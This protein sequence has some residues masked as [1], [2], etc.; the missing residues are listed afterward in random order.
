MEWRGGRWPLEINRRAFAASAS[1][2]LADAPGGREELRELVDPRLRD[3]VDEFSPSDAPPV[4]T[5]PCR[6]LY[7]AAGA[8]VD[9]FTTGMRLRDSAGSL[10][11]RCG[12]S[13]RTG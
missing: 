7:T 8:G 1:F 6:G 5:V 2:V 9:L 4:W 12:M 11:P 3:M 13:A 10:G